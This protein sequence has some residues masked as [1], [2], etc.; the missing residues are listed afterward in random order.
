MKPRR[1]AAEEH[2]PSAARIGRQ[3]VTAA[4]GRS[5]GRVGFAETVC[6]R[7]RKTPGS[8]ETRKFSK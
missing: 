8:V 7:E 3:A 5:R 1:A 2:S 6:G 4:C